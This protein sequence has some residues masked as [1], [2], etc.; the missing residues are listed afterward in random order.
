MPCSRITHPHVLSPVRDREAHD[1]LASR[2]PVFP[3]SQRG[4][5]PPTAE[6]INEGARRYRD[7]PNRDPNFTLLAHIWLSLER[8]KDAPLPDHDAQQAGSPSEGLRESLRAFYHDFDILISSCEQDLD[9]R[10]EAATALDEF[11]LHALQMADWAFPETAL[12]EVYKW[13]ARHALQ[14]DD[15]QLLLSFKRPHRGRDLRLQGLERDERTCRACGSHEELEIDHVIPVSKG[16]A[17]VL[18]NLQVLCH[19]CNISKLAR[20]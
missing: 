14:E 9:A 7:D 18:S 2:P 13:L 1:P 6:A 15:G 3:V 11:L 16:G 10:W 19:A 17:T 12:A 8:W 20:I 4:D 5:E